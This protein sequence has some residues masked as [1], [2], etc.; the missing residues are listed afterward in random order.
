VAKSVIG[1]PLT[2]LCAFVECFFVCWSPSSLVYMFMFSLR[3]ASYLVSQDFRLAA[4]KAKSHPPR[5][6][7]L[8]LSPGGERPD[9]RLRP[10]VPRYFGSPRSKVL[11]PN[12]GP[13]VT[14]PDCE[15]PRETFQLCAARGSTRL[16]SYSRCLPPCLLLVLPIFP[17]SGTNGWSMRPFAPFR[18]QD[19][20]LEW[21]VKAGWN[22]V[23]ELA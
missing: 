16:L 18:T 9:W 5:Q 23:E 7:R 10:T 20:K 15:S 4:L 12:C 14:T 13:T 6:G 11:V 19:I 21:T 1:F 22:L 3:S 17:F 8:K 2:L